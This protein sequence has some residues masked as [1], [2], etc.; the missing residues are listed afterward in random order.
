MHPEGDPSGNHLLCSPPFT[1]AKNQ[2]SRTLSVD[3]RLIWDVGR[4]NILCSKQD[5]WPLETPGIH[6][7]AALYVRVKTRYPSTPK[8]GRSMDIKAAFARRR[9]RP[10]AAAIFASEFIVNSGSNQGSVLLF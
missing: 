7:L 3:K 8:W 6:D 1:V 9:F 4:V 10:G 2:P 5:Y